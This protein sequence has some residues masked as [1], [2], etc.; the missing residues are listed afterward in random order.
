MIKFIFGINFNTKWGLNIYIQP[1]NPEL[2]I[3]KDGQSEVTINSYEGYYG[4]TYYLSGEPVRFKD[5]TTIFVNSTTNFN[6]YK[7]VN[8]KT[9]KNFSIALPTLVG[10]EQKFKLCKN[11]YVAGV[12]VTASLFEWYLIYRAYIG[13]CLYK[14][15]K[16]FVQTQ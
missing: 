8:Y 12:S 5:S 16:A 15:S 13:V 1:L 14:R 2:R 9:N 4:V 7:F 11:T 10:I 3:I 6:N